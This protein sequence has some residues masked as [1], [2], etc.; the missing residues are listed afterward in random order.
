[1]VNLES[2]KTLENGLVCIY[3]KTAQFWQ[4]NEEQAFMWNNFVNI[5]MK[6]NS[7]ILYT[8]I[9][10]LHGHVSTEFHVIPS[11]VLSR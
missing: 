10:S 11:H 8:F 2:D 9:V 6:I 4:M 1:M 3:M 5:Q 7:R